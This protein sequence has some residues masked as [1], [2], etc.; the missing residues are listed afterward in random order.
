MIVFQSVRIM[1]ELSTSPLARRVLL[2]LFLGAL[3]VS[4]ATVLAPFLIPLAWAGILGDL[5]AVPAP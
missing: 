4:V 3:G 1:H 5:A 2:G